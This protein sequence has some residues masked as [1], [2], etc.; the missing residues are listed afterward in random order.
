M[1]QKNH[2]AENAQ[3]EALAE[4]RNLWM[5]GKHQ[6]AEKKC[7][8]ALESNP[9][10]IDTQRFYALMLNA[11]GRVE[12]AFRMLK[13]ICERLN[14]PPLPFHDL[15]RVLMAANNLE[16][17]QKTMLL[18]TQRH[19]LHAPSY[20]ELGFAELRLRQ[21]THAIDALEKSI[22]LQELDWRTWQYWG[23]ALAEIE[24]PDEAVIKFD[25]AL[26]LANT[27]TKPNDPFYRQA[28][29][30]EIIGI[31]MAKS[32]ALNQAGRTGE[33]RDNIR[34]ILCE[35]P[36]NAQAW[37]AL[38]NLM[39][40]DEDSPELKQ[41]ELLAIDAGEGK[42]PPFQR[43]YLD[44][45]L[46]KAWRDSKQPAKAMDYYN[47]GNQQRRAEFNY[48][49]AAACDHLK[50]IA[51]CY[52]AECFADLPP[53]SF[54][55][56]QPNIIFVVG[57]P[58]CGS[59]LTEQILASHQKVHGAGE[60]ILGPK[61][62]RDLFG[63]L[64]PTSPQTNPD[65]ATRA[66]IQQFGENYRAQLEDNLKHRGILDQI[67]R[68][69]IIVDKMLGNFMWIGLILQAIPN[70]R[71]VHC[72]RNPIDTCLSCYSL[73]FS[74]GHPY[75]FN[76]EELGAYYKAY[77]ELMSHWRAVV[78]SD[79]LIEI[80]YEDVVQNT[81]EQAQRLLDFAGLEWTE[82]VLSFHKNQRAVRTASFDQVT[83]PIYASSIARW[84]PYEPYIG[85]LLKA[86]G[87]HSN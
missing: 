38:S 55:P 3:N 77:D 33:S 30:Q 1:T 69:H 84:K 59:T 28:S 61:L 20:R 87:I 40:F 13:R 46:G 78:P 67:G 36:S 10:H 16:S 18:A 2:L 83:K 44:F 23:L 7:R 60:L 68:N 8:T 66:L 6:E 24:T 5:A 39:T 74:S 31:K 26:E 14:A 50:T 76:Q 49:N 57:M 53:I 64:F 79:R 43:Q 73:R 17:A 32:D 54:E 45:A 9:T 80:T 56:D 19:P 86:L 51:N 25:R 62:K 34:E 41:L 81:E 29:L 63:D 52:P 35:T 47:H 75:S 85:P 72:K 4:I 71:F 27:Q 82:N 37:Y 11:S 21:P 12:D 15:M 70:A 42:V 48:D 65:E 58:R 22:E